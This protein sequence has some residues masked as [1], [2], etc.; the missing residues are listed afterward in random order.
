MRVEADSPR[1][2]PQI[3]RKPRTVSLKVCFHP[4]VLINHNIVDARHVKQLL[5][6]APPSS[7]EPCMQQMFAGVGIA[8]QTSMDPSS[9]NLQI[10]ENPNH[11]P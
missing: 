1:S 3:M 11:K 6:L 5:N 8:Q 4:V 7:L 10:N 9:H 2:R